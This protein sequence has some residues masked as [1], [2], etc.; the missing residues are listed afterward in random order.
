MKTMLQRPDDSPFPGLA[1]DPLPGQRH[2]RF[3]ARSRTAAFCS[4]RKSASTNRNLQTLMKILNSICP[5]LFGLG[6]LAIPMAL[7]VMALGACTKKDG[8]AAGG[9]PGPLDRC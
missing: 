2:E 8:A 9:A 7:A 3:P 6:R 1:R 4:L 5:P